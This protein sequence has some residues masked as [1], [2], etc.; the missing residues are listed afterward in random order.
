MATQK[1]RNIW[2]DLFRFLLI[3]M[4]INIHFNEQSFFLPIFRLAVPMFFMISGYFSY[5]KDYNAQMN[6][7]IKSIKASLS[8]IVFGYSFC[9]V[10]GLIL[11]LF[12]YDMTKYELFPYSY[13]LWFLISFFVVW[14]VHFLICKYNLQKIYWYIVPILIIIAL[15]LNICIEVFELNLPLILNRNA[16]FVGLP[17]F[18]IGYLLHRGG[19]V[20]GSTKTKVL[21]LLLAVVFLF[22]SL[23]EAQ[24]VVLEYYICSVFSSVCFLLFFASL[25]VQTNKYIEWYYKYIGSKVVFCIYIIHL[26]IG[27]IIALSGIDTWCLSL[28]TLL[29]AFVVY[30]IVYLLLLILKKKNSIKTE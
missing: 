20:A 14:C 21:T 29:A 2:L 17:M 5:S 3:F 7:N 1:I 27:N 26:F 25:R 23:L 30:E 9:F 12:N 24:I 22:L 15:A 28:L 6:K 13:H 10:V 11:L 8:Y 4:V 18:G 16:F 19:V